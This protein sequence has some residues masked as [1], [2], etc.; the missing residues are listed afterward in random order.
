PRR[1]WSSPG[2]VP[3]SSERERVGR[4]S[5]RRFENE[6]ALAVARAFFAEAAG[7]LA[8]AELEARA[9]A[10]AAVLLALFLAGVAGQ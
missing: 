4:G 3:G 7:R 1:V 2:S 10:T 5:E 9:S 8:L 6:K